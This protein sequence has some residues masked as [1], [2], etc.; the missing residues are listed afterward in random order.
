MSKSKRKTNG[1]ESSPQKPKL[2]KQASLSEQEYHLVHEEKVSPQESIFAESIQHCSIHITHC[3]KDYRP[4]GRHVDQHICEKVCG[5]LNSGGGVLIF[6][7]VD[8]KKAKPTDLDLFLQR[9]EEKLK[10]IIDPSSYGDVFDRSGQ[11]NHDKI[12]F[13]VKAPGH[14]CTVNNHLYLPSDSSIYK[15]SFKESQNILKL[16]KEGEA[17]IPTNDLSSLPAF[18]P[19]ELQCCGELISFHEDKQ[20]QFTHFSSSKELLEQSKHCLKIG[21]CISAFCNGDGGLIFIGIDDGGRVQGQSISNKETFEKKLCSL[22]S[23]MPWEFSP[24]KGTH[25]DVEVFPVKGSSSDSVVGHVIVVSVAGMRSCGGV[26]FKAPESYYLQPGVEFNRD[27]LC[28][29][30]LEEWKERICPD[31]DWE[32]NYQDL[33]KKFK[34]MDIS[35]TPLLMVKDAVKDI[36]KAF[37][38]VDDELFPVIPE[39][40]ESIIPM[41][42]AVIKQIQNKCSGSRRRG[43]L[44]GCHSLAASLDSDT[45]PAEGVVCDLLLISR[46]LGLHLFTLYSS[47]TKDDSKISQYSHASAQALKRILVLKGGCKEKFYVSY[48]VVP[49]SATAV[50][51]PNGDNRYPKSYSMAFT[52]EKLTNI[53]EAL[54]VVLSKVPSTL[55]TKMGVRF[56]HLLTKDQFMLVKQKINDHREYWIQGA[57]GTGKSLVAVEFMREIRRRYRNLEKEEVLYVCE[58]KGMREQTQRA[59]VCQCVCRK[60]FMMHPFPKVK[61]VILDEVQSFKAED[62]DWLEKARMLVGQHSNNPEPDSGLF[63][64]SESEV[65]SEAESDSEMET[66]TES[67]PE[68]VSGSDMELGTESEPEVVSDSD[69]EL[70]TESEPEME[71]ASKAESEMETGAESKSEVESGSETKD[72]P[73]FLWMFIDN[74]QINHYY[75]TGIPDLHQQNPSFRLKKVIRNSKR[76]FDYAKKFLK[77]DAACEIEIGHDF[78]GEDLD[79]FGYSKG[80]R[81]VALKKVLQILL[82]KGY[83]KGEI[84]ILFAKKESIPESALLRALNLE[85][86]VSAEENHCEDVVVSSF[87]MYSGLERP[88]VVLVDIQSSV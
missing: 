39:G 1:N 36:R 58:N 3:K 45:P 47:D 44:L 42:N 79:V 27:E 10:S 51:V 41:A 66:G 48:Q 72:S 76:I 16:Y 21:Q 46:D 53:L 4:D 57:A 26:F 60:S 67:E 23:K 70:G 34:S 68:M 40:F 55:S 73:G 56:L 29:L 78:E 75:K 59:D 12:L 64:R 18:D 22:I 61:H 82:R 14:V 65:G 5:L 74:E 35:G 13:F 20:V 43:L 86:T 88:V 63:S 87:R 49:C 54:V 2:A 71:S 52:R 31:V 50:D 33:L 6:E 11:F 30:G 28:S 77:K 25:W 37:F 85:K 15:A 38:S 69:M 62:G 7:N 9:L 17:H 81:L 19:N 83:S 84:A 8:Y 32:K 80:K 24:V